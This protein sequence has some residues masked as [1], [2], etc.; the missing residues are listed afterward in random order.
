[1]RH[2]CKK[3]CP[4]RSTTCR[5]ECP[6]WAEYE[7]EKAERYAHQLRESMI[8]ATIGEAVHRQVKKHRKR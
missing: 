3:D 5:S 2:P 6:D 4:R 8:V 1:M 7:A